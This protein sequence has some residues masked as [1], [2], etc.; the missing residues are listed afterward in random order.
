MLTDALRVLVYEI[1]LEIFYKKR[2][3]KLRFFI[4]F[5][6]VMSRLSKIN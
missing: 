4:F 6:K 5:M 2:K 1:F 3:K